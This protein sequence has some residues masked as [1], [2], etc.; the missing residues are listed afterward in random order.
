[1]R[2]PLSCAALS[3]PAVNAALQHAVQQLLATAVLHHLA[4]PAT[5]VEVAAGVA[6]AVGLVALLAAALCCAAP[7]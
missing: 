3:P 5:V 4:G 6:A 1:M 2:L 7:G